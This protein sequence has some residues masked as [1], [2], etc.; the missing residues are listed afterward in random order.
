MGEALKGPKKN[1]YGVGQR[2]R[3]DNIK[4]T[5]HSNGMGSKKSRKLGG[6]IFIDLRDRD[7]ILPSSIWRRK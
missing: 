5:T 2:L 1:H 7:G 4:R 6:L 3:E